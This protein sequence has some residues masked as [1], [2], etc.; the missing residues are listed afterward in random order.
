MIVGEMGGMALPG[1]LYDQYGTY[2]ASLL[3]SFGASLLTVAGK[4]HAPT[5]EEPE[6][7]EAIAAMLVR[8]DTGMLAAHV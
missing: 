2:C 4:G 8:V 3:V 7:T 5:L 6:V 1:I